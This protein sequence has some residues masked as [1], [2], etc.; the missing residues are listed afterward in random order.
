[1][2]SQTDIA[3]NVS[4]WISL[5]VE[6]PA[7]L[8]KAIDTLETLRYT[9]IGYAPAFSLEAITQKNAE[10]K[11]R[12]YASELA[13]AEQHG[14]GIQPPLAPAKRY[15]VEAAARQVNRLAREAVP[16]VRDQL[17]PEF[18]QRAARYV[19]AVQELPADLT[20]EALVAG[21]AEAVTAYSVAET[22]AGYL[23]TIDQW[24]SS[25]AYRSGGTLGEPVLRVL[26]P[27]TIGELHELEAAHRAQPNATLR[28]LGPVFYAAAK[29]GTPWGIN[30]L[31]EAAE[32]RASLTTPVSA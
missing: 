13:L 11:L 10:A 18:E 17:E 14:E 30:T 1:M 25:T 23:G 12:A 21:G 5:G 24:V 6:L 22:A 7:V 8:A 15:A 16:A 9:E 29:L 31:P 32:L 19:A 2:Y 28:A 27:G 3:D 4:R 26:R 20:A